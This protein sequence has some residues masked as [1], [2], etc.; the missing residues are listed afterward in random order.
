LLPPRSQQ[1]NAGSREQHARANDGDFADADEI[2]GDSAEAC[3]IGVVAEGH[4]DDPW[5][6]S[7]LVVGKDEEANEAGSALPHQR[8]PASSP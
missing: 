5:V 7:G 1:R 6:R 3:V 2:V 8:L 4:Q